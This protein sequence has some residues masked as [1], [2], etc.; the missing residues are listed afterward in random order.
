MKHYLAL[1][2]SCLLVAS[3]KAA[4]PPR[5]LKVFI[6]AGQSNMEG[7]A[8]ADLDGKDYNDG[9]GTLN[10]LLRDPDKGPLFKHLK[11]TDGTWTKREDVWCRYKREHGPLLAGPLTMGFSVYGDKHHFGPELQFGNVLGDHFE[12]QVLVIKTAWGGKSLFKDFRPPSSG[13]EVG[14]Y[15][16]KM[17]AEIREALANLKRDFPAYDGKGYELAGFVWYHGWNDGVE[18]KKA[19]PEYETNLV[20]L[21]NDVRKD[22][23]A[24]QLPV[25][26]GELTGPWVKAP[27]EW[28]KL[29]KAQ[30]AAAAKKEFEGNVLF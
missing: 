10:F 13:G 18:P 24:P 23:K 20:N 19:V 2:V 28:E 11:N 26:V 21:I 30:A 1:L 6:L 16:T 15:Y 17:I 3:V 25:V 14:P 27:P 12:N 4:D 9:K 29:R 7:Q 8:V 5:V 22:L